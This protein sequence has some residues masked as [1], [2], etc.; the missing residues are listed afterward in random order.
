MSKFES[1]VKR[2]DYPQQTVY[3]KMS[4]LRN[5]EKVRDR[6]PADKVA[7]FDSGEDWVSLSVAPI[8]TVK[9]KIVEREEPKCI[10][11]ETEK[12]PFPFTLWVQ[13]LPLDESS[14][15][16]KLTVKAEL[17]PFIK[18]LI[19]KPL[20]EGVEKVADAITLIRFN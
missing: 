12:S 5:L 14:C 1:S 10:K 3:E 15:K 4:D 16:M 7:D 6:I 9:L 17:N 19:E 18:M 11:M 8:G 2:L 20:T 13:L